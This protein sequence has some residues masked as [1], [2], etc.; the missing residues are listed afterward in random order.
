MIRI[1]LL[2]STIALFIRI[3]L[4]VSSIRRLPPNSADAVTEFKGTPI[5]YNIAFL[6]L[7]KVYVLRKVSMV[8]FWNCTV[9]KQELHS[10]CWGKLEFLFCTRQFR[11]G[12]SMCKAGI[13]TR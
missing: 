12:R 13:G 8:Q 4:E 6:F 11:K 9:Q 1:Q 5:R 3:E 10:L 2:F 7:F